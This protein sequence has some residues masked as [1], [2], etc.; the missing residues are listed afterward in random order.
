MAVIVSLFDAS[1]NALRPWAMAGHR[2]YAF[3]ILNLH[4]SVHFKSGGAIYWMK[5][6]LMNSQEI[7]DIF[8]M[9]PAFISGF[10]PCTDMA[11]SGARHFAAKAAAD[12]EF[13][14]KAAAMARVV[15]T[16]G[17]KCGVPWYAEN[18]VSVLSTLWRKPNHSFHPWEYGAYLPEDD[19]HPNWPDYIAPRD[20][21]PKKTCIWSGNGFQMPE[22]R[23][24]ITTI[25]WSVS[26]KFENYSTQFNKLGGKSAKTKQIRS[27]TPRGWAEAVFQANRHL[28]ER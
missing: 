6:D 16:L 8:A 26:P 19:V 12:P 9:K 13:Q 4:T 1:G 15:E 28:V 25:D 3:D 24:V 5:A 23:P 27:E 7:L 22:K 20:A 10:P 2:C 17:E 18:P 21:Y 14:N 11:V